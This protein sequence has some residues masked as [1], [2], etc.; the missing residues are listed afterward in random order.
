MINFM[1]IFQAHENNKF[2]I[3][4][5]IR[6]KLNLNNNL[7]YK[8]INFCHYNLTLVVLKRVENIQISV[9]LVF[10]RLKVIKV[11]LSNN[12]FLYLCE[13]TDTIISFN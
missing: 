7:Y 12:I 2:N 3:N 13:Q 5:C 11:N 9:A 10:L 4:L 1:S 8:E 6:Q